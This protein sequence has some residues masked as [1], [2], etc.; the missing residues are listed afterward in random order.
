MV[1]S[2]R[3]V[4]ASLQ[5]PLPLRL[6][7]Y[8]YLLKLFKA[9]FSTRLRWDALERPAYGYGMYNAALLARALGYPEITAIEFG[10]AG[11]NGLVAMEEMAV[12][13]EKEIGVKIAIWGFDSSV[14]LPQSSDVRDQVYFWRAGDFKMDLPALQARLK[15][16]Q[17]VIAP[18]ATSVTDFIERHKPP[19]IG[20]IAFDLDYYSSTQDALTIFNRGDQYFLP[21]VECHMDDISSWEMLCASTQTG[22]LAAIGGFNSTSEFIKVL[23]KEDLGRSRRLPANWFNA[24]YIAHFF[25][26][27]R[28][29]DN[30]HGFSGI[31]NELRLND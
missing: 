26:H 7:A 3:V 1:R 30:V 19:P 10:V 5:T 14:G 18:I 22:V 4:L 20:F 12:E 8:Q 13:I 6:L 9:K 15:S 17:L 21:R 2:L 23:K 28:Y 31:T 11:G 25:H 27:K 24:V 16:A 29:N